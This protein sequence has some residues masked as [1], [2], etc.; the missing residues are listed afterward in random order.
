[1]RNCTHQPFNPVPVPSFARDY[2]K[3][4]WQDQTSSLHRQAKDV[5]RSAQREGGPSRAAVDIVPLHTIGR[6]DFSL[7]DT[8]STLR[9]PRIMKKRFVDVFPTAS[10]RFEARLTHVEHLNLQRMSLDDC[11]TSSA[12]VTRAMTIAD[13]A[14]PWPRPIRAP[15]SLARRR[16]LRPPRRS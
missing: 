14:R 15:L 11:E 7:V 12:A 13:R 3:G 9:G 1:M 8:A 6:L 2:A 10:P 5:H 4:S 16:A